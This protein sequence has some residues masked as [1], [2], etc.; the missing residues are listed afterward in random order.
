MCAFL[1]L[2]SK[3]SF[4]FVNFMCVHAHVCGPAQDMYM[5][6]RKLLLG[7]S[8]FCDTVTQV[9]TQGISLCSTCEPMQAYRHTERLKKNL[10]KFLAYVFSLQCEF[11]LQPA[12]RR[13][14]LLIYSDYYFHCFLCSL[15][16]WLSRKSHPWGRGLL[17]GSGASLDD[18]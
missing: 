8:S 14:S 5:K 4:F 15:W 12:S 17:I 9:Q 2:S 13:S 18:W 7:V 10:K 16:F 11:W 3:R 6:V 1:Y